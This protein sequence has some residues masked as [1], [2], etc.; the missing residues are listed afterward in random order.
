MRLIKLAALKEGMVLGKNIYGSDMRILLSK[1]TVLQKEY[2][3]KIDRYNLDAVYID[4]EFTSDIKIN[5]IIAPELRNEMTAKIKGFFSMP[6]NADAA[7]YA[8]LKK[9]ASVLISKIID[10]ILKD[11]EVVVNLVNLKSH[12]EYTYQH[13]VNVGVLCAVMGT[14]LGYTTRDITELTTAGIFHDIGKKLISKNIL[15]KPGKLTEE[16]FEVIKAHPKLGYDFA[17]KYLNFSST[18]LNAILLHHER[19]DG[20]GYPYRRSGTEISE[21]AQIVAICDVF[22][23]MTSNRVYH[24]AMLPSEA[25]E[26]LMASGNTQFS[27]KIVEAFLRKIA[28]YPLGMTVELSDGRQGVVCQNTQGLTLRPKV[29]LF[30]GEIVDLADMTSG[31]IT[32]TR[33]IVE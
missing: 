5:D 26:Y 4:D 22:D 11:R 10:D 25:V 7:K 28:A 14:S 2:I 29:K 19:W 20:S 12:D 24:D 32:I 9:E 30:T 33:V 18:T 21:F 6:E 13:S 1:G 3:E 23:A 31:N 16:E 17:Q 27:S 15:T 8:G